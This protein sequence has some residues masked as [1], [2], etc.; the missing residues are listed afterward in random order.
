VDVFGAAG[1]LA[2]NHRRQSVGAV[3]VGRLDTAQ[4]VSVVVV[5]AVPIGLPE[6]ECGSRDGVALVVE[7]VTGKE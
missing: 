1:V 7:D 6:V 5:G 4:D 2:W 3:F